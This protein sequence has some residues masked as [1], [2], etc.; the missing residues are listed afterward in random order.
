MGV[1]RG[2][3]SR[4]P[5][6][7]RQS[8]H[9]RPTCGQRPTRPGL[10]CL[11]GTEIVRRDDDVEVGCS[12][13]SAA[14]VNKPIVPGPMTTARSPRRRHCSAACSPIEAGSPNTA[15]RDG[16]SPA[17][18]NC[19]SW[20]TTC[21]DHPPPSRASNPRWVNSSRSPGRSNR[22]QTYGMAIGA[23]SADLLEATDRHEIT[24]STITRSPSTTRVTSGPVSATTATISCRGFAAR[25]CRRRRRTNDDSG[26]M[27][28]QGHATDAAQLRSQS[29]PG[30]RP[31]SRG[32]AKSSRHRSTPPGPHPARDPRCFGAFCAAAVKR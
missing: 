19:D 5:S 3:K 18:C 29:H 12:I 32:V 7:P 2:R 13:R 22:S 11:P 4:P 25:R 28:R 21:S 15:R 14:V 9:R 1:S 26:V 16:M 10:L 31:G 20:A 30:C 6:S 23:G 17:R 27:R 8:L 24:G